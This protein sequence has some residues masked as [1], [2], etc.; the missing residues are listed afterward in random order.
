MKRLVRIVLT[1]VLPLIATAT[2]AQNPPPA[3]APAPAGTLPP[4]APVAS[5]IRL[6]LDLAA[7]NVAGNTNTTTLN[8]GDQFEYKTKRARFS[9]FAN[10]IYGRTEGV[11]T[12]ENI[13]AGLRAEHRLL[14]VVYGYL[15]VTYE[16]DSIAGIDHRFAES[17]GVLIRLIDLPRDLWTFE[18]GSDVNQSRSTLA[19]VRNFVSLRFATVIRHNFTQSAYI[20]ESAET[21]PSVENSRDYRIN[22]ETAL[23]APLSGRLALKVSYLVR[24]A[25]LPEIPTAKQTDR[26]LSTG[27][28]IAF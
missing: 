18:A 4:P 6:T 7:V 22:S 3:P 14:A 20:S 10:L 5:P 26:T 19:K 8:L 1:V 9:Q 2:F 13:K 28:Q 21:L 23:V 25:H 17:G 16:R 15:G 24:Y 27:V 11:T 12:A